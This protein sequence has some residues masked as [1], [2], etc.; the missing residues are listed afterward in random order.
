[1]SILA[2]SRPMLFFSLGLAL[3]GVISTINGY[4]LLF[5]LGFLPGARPP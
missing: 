2:A 4:F 1:V 3:L 5:R